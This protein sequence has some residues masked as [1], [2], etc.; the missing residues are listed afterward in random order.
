MENFNIKPEILLLHPTDLKGHIISYK[1][2]T[3]A[4]IYIMGKQK[5]VVHKSQ[6]NF[7]FDILY[8][9]CCL[10]SMTILKL[11]EGISYKHDEPGLSFDQT[12]DPFSILSLSRAQLEAYCIFNNILIESKSEEEKKLKHDIWVLSGLLNRQ[13]FPVGKNIE[14]EQKK[15]KELDKINDL[16]KAIETNHTF[17]CLNSKSQ[18]LITNWSRITDNWKLV[19]NSNTAHLASWSE[20][21]QNS[22][23]AGFE[24]EYN[25][26]LLSLYTHPT[27]VS[28]FQ[29]NSLYK[30]GQD[31][32]L[33]Q[34]AL[35]FSKWIMSFFINDICIYY[36]LTEDKLPELPS[37][38]KNLVGIYNRQMRPNSKLF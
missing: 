34:M 27:N 22:G 2:V 11:S 37:L 13:K 30:N 9:M 35:S 38:N 36:E 10:K 7:D 4:A 25:Y 8:Q 12:L 1:T 14:F 17:K 15:A 3:D 33:T 16:K 6:W 32:F 21:V 24:F 26:R 28:V 29:F 20:L 19:I 23:A 5:G 18:S 31:E